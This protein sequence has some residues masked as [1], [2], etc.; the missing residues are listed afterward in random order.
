MKW[1]SLRTLELG[2]E[3]TMVSEDWMTV[4]R[5]VDVLVGAKMVEEI[6]TFPLASKLFSFRESSQLEWIGDDQRCG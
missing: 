5:I 4:V 3:M 6:H 1:K 2:E